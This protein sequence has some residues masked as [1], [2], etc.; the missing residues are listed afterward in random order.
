[1]NKEGWNKSDIFLRKEG[2]FWRA[3]EL[4]AV[5]HRWAGYMRAD[6]DALKL[7]CARTVKED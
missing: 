3:C 4:A 6:R 5:S 1:M 2:L 7:S